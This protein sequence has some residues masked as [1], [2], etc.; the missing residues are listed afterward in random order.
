MVRE[1]SEGL[2]SQGSLGQ[3]EQQ[4]VVGGQSRAHA[5]EGG[6]PDKQLMGKVS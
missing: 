4:A 3:M 5:L 2:P 6:E 1:T